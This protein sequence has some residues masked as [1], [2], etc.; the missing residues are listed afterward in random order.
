M[1]QSKSETLLQR[2][3]A[4]RDL[5]E[6]KKI[7]RGD[8]DAETLKEG[9]N[10]IL[11][12]TFRQKKENF[13]FYHKYKLIVG[14][15]ILIVL[16][17][18]IINTA[19]KVKYDAKTVFFSF[20]YYSDE[21]TVKSSDYFESFYEDLNGNGN[22]DI[23]TVNCSFDQHG[24]D[25]EYAKNMLTKVQVLLIGEEDTMLYILD[26]DALEFLNGISDSVKLFEEENIFPLGA[27]YFSA[28]EAEPKELYLCLR[29]VDGTMLEGKTG[30]NYEA[31]RTAF[32]KVKLARQPIQNQN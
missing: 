2:E 21:Q 8:L 14:V 4:Q 7:Q 11:P 10:P 9:D 16:T 26:K 6:L 30:K 22:V 23:L 29:T 1:K 27:D 24:N 18:L 17:F 12:E 28:I 13:L 32:E 3:K 15:F 5:L 31:A 25:A 20:D 19:T